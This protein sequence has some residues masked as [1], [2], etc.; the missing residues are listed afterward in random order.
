MGTGTCLNCGAALHGEFCAACG[1]AADVGRLQS[2]A[3]LRDVLEDLL[4]FDTRFLRTVRA[5]TV[6][7]GRLCRDYAQGRRVAWFPPLRYFLGM[8]AA[9]LLVMLWVGFDP[10]RVVVDPG[11]AGSR[12]AR[13]Q[14]AVAE[15][16]LANLNVSMALL[17]P[18]YAGVLR[19]LFR[20]SGWNYAEC[21]V[22]ALYT[23]GHCLLFSLLIEPVKLVA[24]DV[25]IVLRLGFQWAYT[26]WA[27]RVF[28]DVGP[29]TAIWRAGA[30][31]LAYFVLQNL[32]VIA[33]AVPA[34]MRA[35]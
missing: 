3:L 23:L 14:R 21:G 27:A 24:F 6:A 35:W 5:L 16:A 4:H 25:A 29:G 8:L 15:S 10:V 19:W 20:R 13:V 26:A 1:Q 18:L 33:I 32:V 2:K 30:A 12:V 31:T 7:P 17:A 28:F 9:V 11:D 34:I 22:F